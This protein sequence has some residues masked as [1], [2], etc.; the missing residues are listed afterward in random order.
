MR[1]GRRNSLTAMIRGS[2][3]SPFLF[4]SSRHVYMIDRQ[5]RALAYGTEAGE[6]PVG[7]VPLL[8]N[9]LAVI[10]FAVYVS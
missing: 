1:S 9:S 3:I 2:L 5:T 4:R 8:H 7:L 6:D 10:Q